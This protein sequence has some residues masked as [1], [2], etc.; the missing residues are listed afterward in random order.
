VFF[1]NQIRTGRLSA[2]LIK[3]L[4][5]IIYDVTNNLAEKS[6]KIS[7][8][9]PLILLGSLFFP[10]T[11]STNSQIIILTLLGLI[12]SITIA[13][14]IQ[15]CIGFIGFWLEDV[16]ALLNLLDISDYTIGG[17]FIPFFLLPPAIQPITKYL[18]FRYVHAFPAE[19]IS[20]S[21]NTAE[22]VS[23]LAIQ[24][25]WIILLTF[26]AFVLWRQGIKRY[27]AVGG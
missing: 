8:L 19:I 11:L 25:V 26:T 13:F 10:L 16:S 3:P 18:P 23:G 24:L 22:V 20:Q 4:P 5:V 9:L 14:L 15:T 7:F 21:I 6:T 12:L 2:H 27:T 17:R 1:A